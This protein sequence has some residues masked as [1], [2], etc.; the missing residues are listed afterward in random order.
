LGGA[1]NAMF[2]SSQDDDRCRSAEFFVNL[3]Q[4]VTK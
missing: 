4:K 3:L 2:Q 1:Q